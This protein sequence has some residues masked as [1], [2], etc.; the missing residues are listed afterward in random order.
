MQFLLE[1]QGTVDVLELTV[2]EGVFRRW[3]LKYRAALFEV[4]WKID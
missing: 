3:A 4:V 2:I 1:F